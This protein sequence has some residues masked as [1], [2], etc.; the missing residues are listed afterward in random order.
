MHRFCVGMLI[1]TLLVFSGCG[2]SPTSSEQQVASP[3]AGAPPT[4]PIA[5][6][7]YDFLEAV[8]SSDNEAARAK[9][10][11]LAIQRMAE[12]GMDFLLPISKGAQFSVSKAELI[13]NDI[14]AVDT[15]WTEVDAGGQPFREELTVV[16]KL[17]EGRWGIMAVLS[18][19]GPNQEPDGIDF[20]KPDQ[21]FNFAALASKPAAVGATT[22]ASNSTPQQATLPAAQ[23]PFR[24]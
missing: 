14:A 20:E 13:E 22:P 1:G 21:P 5:T 3:P 24:Q 4:D 19:M 16:L 8:R 23:D 2:K 18:G 9:L 15:I 11:P 12:L 6:I 17:G 10:T 7:A